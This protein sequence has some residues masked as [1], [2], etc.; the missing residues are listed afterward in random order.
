MSS[1]AAPAGASGNVLARWFTDLRVRTKILT[2]VLTVAAVVTA[3]CVLAV[4]RMGDMDERMRTL[5]ATNM[6]NL[7]LLG[8]IR[9]TQSAINHFST[10]LVTADTP[11]AA[12][13]EAGRGQAAAMKQLDATLTAYTA[14]PKAA[15]TVETLREFTRNWEQFKAAIAAAS[16]GRDPG[17]DFDSVISGMDRS[18][19]DLVDEEDATAQAAARQ[20]HESYLAARRDVLIALAVALLAGTGLAL[21]VARS[22]TRRLAPVAAAM[23]AMADGDLNRSVPAGGRDEIGAMARS[24]NRATQSVRETVTALAETAELLAHNSTELAR[25]HDQTVTGSRAVTGQ[26]EAANSSAAEVSASLRTVATGADEMAMAIE[27]IAQ[28]ATAS[29]GVTMEAVSVVAETTETVSK[30]GVS[31]QEIGAVVKVITSIAEQ[32]NLLALNATIEAARAGESGKGFAVVAGEVKELAQETAK[33]TEDISRRVQAIQGDTESAVAAITRIGEVIEKINHFQTTIASAVE[34]QTAT[35]AE[36]NRNVTAAA[37]GAS[38]IARNIN[39]VSGAAEQSTHG[40]AA[41][42]QA[43]T[44]LATLAEDLNRLVRRFSYR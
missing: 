16:Q 21:T 15:A 25:V 22:L 7:I 17:V 38:E 13:A 43:A 33:A 10:A 11:A 6:Q 28:S 18:I 32:T 34:E 1:P 26:A 37:A 35:T 44:E 12:R 39:E 42:Q 2:T 30:L 31:S 27:E 40:I 19:T 29:A 9:G 41:G 5:Q 14:Q 23:D 8:R 36:M 24:V 3:A 20:A 4:T